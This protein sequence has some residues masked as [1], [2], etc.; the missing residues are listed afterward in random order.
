MRGAWEVPREQRLE[1]R[2][3]QLLDVKFVNFRSLRN[4]QLQ[5]SCD[6]ESPLT[7]IRAE[8]AIGKTTILTAMTWA[9]F[10]DSALLPVKRS[11]FRLHPLDWDT[12]TE[13]ERCEISVEV[14]FATIDE[15]NQEVSY[16]HLIRNTADLVQVDGRYQPQADSLSLLRKTANG[17]QAVKNPSAFIENSVLLPSL[18]DIFFIDGDRALAFIEAAGERSSK[19]KRVEAAVRQLLGIDILE[20]AQRHVKEAR[21]E[22]V[23]AVRA[24]AKGTGLEELAG[25]EELINLRV[26]NLRISIEE[27]QADRTATD[28]RLTKA[29]MAL[30]QILVSGGGDKKRIAEDLKNSESKLV[31]ERKHYEDSVK[32][33]R[34]QLNGS[35]LLSALVEPAVRKASAKLRELEEQKIIPN[36]LPD[37]VLDRLERGVCICGASVVPGTKGHEILCEVITETQRLGEHHEVLMHLNSSAN[38]RLN[39]LASAPVWLED[40]SNAQSAVAHSNQLISDLE[41]EVAELHVRIKNLPDR[42]ITEAEDLVRTEETL[43]DEVMTDLAKSEGQL[44]VLENELAKISR[45]RQTAASKEKRYLKRLA[46]ERAAND[47]LDVING[48]I[49]TLQ[50]DTLGEVSS[51]MNDIFMNMIVTDVESP[52]GNIRRAELTPEHDIVVHGPEQ[53]MLDPDRDLSG[54]QR[55]ALTLAFILAL[56]SVSGVRAPNII[57]TPLGMTSGE[58]RK[59]VVRYA[60]ENSTQLILFLTSDEIKGV[61]NLLDKFAGRVYTLSHSDHYPKRLKNPPPTSRSETLV[62]ECDYRSWC[63][64]CELVEAV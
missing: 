27:M 48:T 49:D 12:M 42:N 26:S 30:Q 61:E 2:V 13:G 35:T 46:E 36:T 64:V 53:R 22:A 33:L 21:S 17:F 16:Y 9:L 24:E 1:S 23:R 19:R 50:I 5:F 44:A 45:E 57:D 47:L 43:R 10:G 20:V 51:K 15:R 41:K 11:T 31:A 62:C 7:V 39:E 25:R 14:K 37:I 56:V 58:V 55:R 38:R 40:A 63:Q 34:R 59:A 52:A 60:A 6:E 18:K 32:H 28:V 54:A 29:R 4:V 3:I 8:N